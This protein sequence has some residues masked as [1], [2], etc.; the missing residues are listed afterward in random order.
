VDVF[1]DRAVS[2]AGSGK[3]IG[4]MRRDLVDSNFIRCQI[5]RLKG[6]GG[7]KSRVRTF[8]LN[9]MKTTFAAVGKSA[10]MLAVFPATGRKI[11]RRVGRQEGQKQ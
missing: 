2:R 8:L 7:G 6:R 10:M 11:R 3:Q 4:R 9:G 5:V 1:E